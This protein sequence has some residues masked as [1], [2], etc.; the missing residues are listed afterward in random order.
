MDAELVV[1]LVILFNIGV[2]IF[3]AC[4]RPEPVDPE[5]QFY[6]KYLADGRVANMEIRAVRVPEI[7]A[8]VQALEKE[9]TD[10]L[11]MK[12]TGAMLKA[13]YFARKGKIPP[14]LRY[15]S[16][17]FKNILCYRHINA[18]MNQEV[19]DLIK[20]GYDPD[21][22]R[23]KFDAAYLKFLKWYD[24]TLDENGVE[25]SL[26]CIEHPKEHRIY[27]KYLK[28]SGKEY[29]YYYKDRIELSHCTNVHEVVCFWEPEEKYG[30]KLRG[31][32]AVDHSDWEW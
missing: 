9:L 1:W 25:C 4:T 8:E 16:H 3:Y 18:W 27:D 11:G 14:E 12:P 28:R 29:V 31:V 13:A 30:Q 23:D 19:G 24:V 26:M 2:F 32:V 15:R 17:D 5:K 7:Y 20:V 10:Y 22:F 6:E 21:I